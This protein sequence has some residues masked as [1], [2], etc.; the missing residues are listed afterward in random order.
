MDFY[1][2]CGISAILENLSE[3]F[4]PKKKKEYHVEQ[5]KPVRFNYRPQFLSEYIGQER[6]KDLVT[7]NL[8]K[9]R[10][11]KPV[12]FVISGHKG[13]GKST[14]AN[15]IANELR[16]KMNWYIAGAF[17]MDNLQKFL[18]KNQDSNDMEILFI[19]EGHNLEKI[20]AEYMYP[21]LEDFLLPEGENIKLKPFIFITATTDMNLLL[22]KFSPLVDRCGANIVLEQYKP[23]EIKQILIQYNDKLYQRNISLEIYN[24]LAHNT[25]GT[26]RI[27]LAFLDDFIVSK[28]INRVLNAHRVIKEGLTTIDILIL[29]HLKEVG[30]PVGIEALAMIASVTRADFTYVIEPYLIANNYL[31]RT[32]RGRLI[33]IKGEQLLQEIK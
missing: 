17:S 7:L 25:R 3:K 20:I 5:I 19:D 31:T 1:D 28:D 16:A 23:E 8:E 32:S 22:K 4:F 33:T 2:I 18:I 27:A 21:I 30:K 14:L 12:H 10:T 26:P 6:A 13:A 24:I 29:S 15:I 9:I 11:I